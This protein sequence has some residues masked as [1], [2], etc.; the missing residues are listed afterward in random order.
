MQGDPVL[1]LASRP[2]R[3]GPV[4][5]VLPARVLHHVPPAPLRLLRQLAL[6]DRAEGLLRGGHV[7]LLLLATSR[8]DH[9]VL[10]PHRPQGVAPTRARR[11]Q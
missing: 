4:V 10:Q 1:H 3:H 5:G 9:C 7:R 2:G 6:A 8:H 11:A